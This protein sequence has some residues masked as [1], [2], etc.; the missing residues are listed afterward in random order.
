[1]TPEE[2]LELVL[3][4]L[5]QFNIPYMITGSFASNIHSVP[6]ATFDAD[7]V[8]EVAPKSLK[9]F[10]DSLAG[11]FYVSPEAAE[12]ALKTR[13]MFNIIHLETG[14]KVDLI[15]KKDRAF[16]QNE[17]SR[18]EKVTYMDQERWFA[19]AEDMILAKLEW[20]RMGESEKQ[21][22]DALNVAK[23]QGKNLDRSYLQKWAQ[24]LGVHELLQKLFQD[25]KRER[26]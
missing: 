25:L 15:I 23:V 17:F 19:T 21:F 5:D 8:I 2:A 10:L 14:F 26:S 12:E 20:S 4:R 7:V 16:S 11:E 9:K 18:R 1:M 24:E 3:S 6:R 13:R 22:K